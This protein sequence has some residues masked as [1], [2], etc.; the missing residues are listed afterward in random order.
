MTPTSKKPK[1]PALDGV[2][3][4][5]LDYIRE[6]EDQMDA[7]AKRAPSPL[8]IAKR[9]AREI[10]QKSAGGKLSVGDVYAQVF[11]EDPDLYRQ[12]QNTPHIPD[13]TPVSLAP[14]PVPVAPAPAPSVMDA[15]VR[16][17]FKRALAEARQVRQPRTG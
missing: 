17:I 9:R 2:P 14:T 3:Q 5:V 16:D 8:E 13:A 11:R 1:K 7:L 12:I 4:P 10:V 15:V 6:M